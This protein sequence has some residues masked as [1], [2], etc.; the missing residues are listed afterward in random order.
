MRQ[1]DAEEFQKVLLVQEVA[2][3]PH[4][5]VK[6]LEERF[7]VTSIVHLTKKDGLHYYSK[8]PLFD[9][10]YLVI[11]EDL[12]IFESNIVYL[13]MD[14]M[15]PVVLCRTKSAL[16]DATDICKAK[17]LKYSS[18]INA[19]DKKEA[20]ALIEELASVKVSRDFCD[21]LIRRVGYS[22]QRLISAVMVCEQVGYK[23]SNISRYVDKYIY[24]DIYDVIDSLLGQCKSQAQRKR[25]ALYLHMNR[26]WYRRY[27]QVSLC[28]EVLLLITIFRDLVNGEL[29]PYSLHEYL[30]RERLPKYKV[31]YAL[32]LYE[33][34][35]LNELL[36][37]HHFLET[38]TLLEVAMRLS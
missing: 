25:A 22:P 29:T 30:D 34:V 14:F 36:A 20:I 4:S 21:S 13:R 19:F 26:I 37:L 5:I 32:N 38:A 8:P 16:A 11:I 23:S 3:H 9:D 28:K 17:G 24:I 33:T 27:T 31:M 2:L 7:E 10:K 12:R 18:Y 1:R 15:F 35:S 6:R